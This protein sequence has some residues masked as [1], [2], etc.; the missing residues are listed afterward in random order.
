M[1]PTKTLGEGYYALA[2]L[3][4][5]LPLEELTARLKEAAA[6]V[7]TGAVSQAIRDTAEARTGEYIGFSGKDI[8]CSCISREEA[9]K[10]LAEKLEAG[11]ADIFILFKGAGVP[12]EEADALQSAFAQSYP[13]TEVILLDGGQPV[14]DYLLV[15]C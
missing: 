14:Y 6:S 5:E 11:S 1:I 15:L 4:S 7:T 12:A 2:N 9:V 8:L 13:L 3:D 10:T